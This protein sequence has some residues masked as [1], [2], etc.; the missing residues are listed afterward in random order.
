MADTVL[1]AHQPA[2]LPWGG[3][4]ARLLDVS[5]LVVLDHVQFS[6]RGFQHRNRILRPGGG[7]QWLTVPVRRRFGQPLDEVVLAEQ[8]WARRHWRTLLQNYGGTPFWDLYADPIAEIYGRPWTH[9]VDLDLALIRFVL[10][11]LD[12]SVELVRSS[13][14]GPAGSRTAML[15]DLCRR[16]GAE[17]LRSGTGATGYLNA[18]DL[19]VAGISVEVATVTAPPYRQVGG[20]PFTSNLSV[21]DLL[22]HHG[23]HAR[24][25][26]AEGAATARWSAIS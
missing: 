13:A 14:I 21:L 22:L 26:L 6:E 17:T 1:V 10:D 23:P 3:Y 12:L 2:Y 19:D 15:I 9:L 4:F 20:G 24:A 11:A 8:P 16:T 25:V 7:A 18:A 5:R